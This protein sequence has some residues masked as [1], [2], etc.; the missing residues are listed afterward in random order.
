MGRVFWICKMENVGYLFLVKLD[1][2][3]DVYSVYK[4]FLR[5]K[6]LMKQN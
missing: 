1:L 5:S 2:I 3:N 4:I 6:I